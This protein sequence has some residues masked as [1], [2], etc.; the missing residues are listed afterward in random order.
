MDRKLLI[1]LDLNGNK[2]KNAVIDSDQIK[3]DSYEGLKTSDPDRLKLKKTDNITQHIEKLER[4]ISL[5]T[6]A[7]PDEVTD[8]C[9][10][11]W[12]STELDPD[13]VTINGSRTYAL[14]WHPFL[15]DTTDNTKMTTT[16]KAE[17]R[18]SCWFKDLDGIFMPTI[19][20]TQEMYNQCME[21]DLYINL[22]GD[23]SKY[24]NS[25]EYNPSAYWTSQCKLTDING[26]LQL[27]NTKLYILSN[28]QYTEVTHYLMP[29]ETPENKYS[30]GI[31]RKD[32]VYLVDLHEH[33]DKFTY[34]G[35]VSEAQS[36]IDEISYKKYKLPPTAI[37]PSPC[38][39]VGNKMRTFYNLYY[40]G[41]QNCG[42]NKGDLSFNGL[43][44]KSTYP[45]TAD[46]SQSTNLT[47]ARANNSD[48]NRSYPYAEGSFHAYNTFITCMEIGYGTKY[49]NKSTR[50]SS[51]ISSTDTCDS[52]TTWLSNGGVRFRRQG[53]TDWEYAK[54]G[55]KLNIG[56][57]IFG[58][59]VS[60][61]NA[62]SNLY[63]VTACNEP[64]MAASYAAL[65]RIPAGTHF[66]F[67]GNEYWYENIDAILGAVSLLDGEMNCRV[68]KI[69][70]TTISGYRSAIKRTFDIEVILR[71]GL[72]QGVNISGDIW[73]YCGGGTEIVGTCQGSAKPSTGNPI[74][75]YLEVD[76][77]KWHSDNLSFKNN[78]GIWDFENN[79]ESLANFT[80]SETG[81]TMARI[82][83]TCL[84]SKLGGSIS[85]GE[86]TYDMS[87][88]NWSDVANQRA[89]IGVMLRGAATLDTC[90]I[91]SNQSN[92]NIDH[93]DSSIGGSMQALINVK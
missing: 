91:R 87:N 40:N 56:T 54:W 39:T 74:K 9:I 26:V 70:R 88:C 72:I 13:A 48:P 1:N 35:I 38:M 84:K 55:D 62:L 34:K 46:V 16:P 33:N 63:P 86:C 15:L 24:C 53:T 85:T 21:N 93:V 20:I 30:I 52:E 60:T 8:Y 77:S 14:D 6:G 17:L 32:T 64:Q 10:G 79:Y 47:M 2:I 5:I 75:A 11:V 19:G 31:G 3:M 58:N 41:D 7:V 81:W 25:G 22:N 92:Y 69:I 71:T 43:Y 51:G 23:Y 44:Q 42:S 18:N 78:N 57:N 82:P 12:N 49:L 45:R 28:G 27:D 76:Q 89:R 29:W 61:S 90:A 37:S 36:T 80:N 50:F 67:N 83:Y 59:Q 68:Y 4:K 66:I 73:C 65:N